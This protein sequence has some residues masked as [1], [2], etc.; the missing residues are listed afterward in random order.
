MLRMTDFEKISLIIYALMRQLDVDQN[1]VAYHK[2]GGHVV[3]RWLRHCATNWK[4][5]G[6]IPNGVI[7]IFD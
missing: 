2:S 5:V 1:G 4:V 6:S 3:V 7:R